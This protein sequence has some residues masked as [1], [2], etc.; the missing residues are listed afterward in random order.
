MV[1]ITLFLSWI[2]QVWV[3]A[4]AEAMEEGKK[5]AD[6]L[7]RQYDLKSATAEECRRLE[8]DILTEEKRR[9]IA[10]REVERVATI[11]AGERHTS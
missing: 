5:V 6:G 3:D 11:E 1:R 7:T 8:L 4:L 10:L 2:D 9:L